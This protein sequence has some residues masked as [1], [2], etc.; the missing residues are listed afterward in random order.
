MCLRRWG[1]NLTEPHPISHA[2]PDYRLKSLL[3][4]ECAKWVFYQEV[5][6]KKR[7]M[8]EMEYNKIEILSLLEYCRE[9]ILQLLTRIK[10]NPPE[11]QS[12]VDLVMKKRD[13]LQKYVMVLEPILTG[14][15]VMIEDSIKQ[16]ST[17]G[18]LQ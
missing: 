15:E 18:M 10:D 16:L 3:K 1:T 8:E 6:R 14:Y 7:A 11:A 2:E 9:D 13:L 12:L 5:L 17:D 4:T